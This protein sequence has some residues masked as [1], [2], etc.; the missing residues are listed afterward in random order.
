MSAV[1]LK[2]SFEEFQ[3]LAAQGNLI[4]VW[5][6]LTADYETP[7]S[8]FEKIAD[9]APR[10]LFESA[11]TTGFSGRYSFM[12]A[13]PRA[14]ITARGREVEVKSRDGKVETFQTKGD[15]LKDLEAVMS[16]F[17]PVPQPLLPVFNGGAVGVLTYDMVRFSSPPSL[18]HRRTNWASRKWCSSLPTASLS[19]TTATG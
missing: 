19:S 1:P 13:H 7:L 17:R 5:A 15:P 10:F 14:V 6:E 8:A 3:S 16:K 12:G 18:L 9:G 11:E 2:P 4:P